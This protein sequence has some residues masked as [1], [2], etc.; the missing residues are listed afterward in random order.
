MACALSTFL[1]VWVVPL[2]I[3]ITVPSTILGVL[4]RC[5][6]FWCDFCWSVLVRLMYSFPLFLLVWW[7][8]L[9]TSLITCSFPSSKLPKAFLIWSFYSFCWFSFPTFPYNHG[10]FSKAKFHCFILGVNSYCVYQDLQFF[11]KVFANTFWSSRF[12]RWLNFCCYLPPVHFL[13]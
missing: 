8:L 4:P 13:K 6:S 12:I 2:S 10:T 3:L 7:F 9:P 1:S 5:L 11:F